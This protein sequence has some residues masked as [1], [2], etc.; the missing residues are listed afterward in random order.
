MFDLSWTEILLIGVAAIIFIGPKELPGA[1][2]ALGRWMGKARAMAREF[3]SNVDDM[4]RE[5]EIADLKKEVMKIES[6]EF[7]RE[8][9]KTVDPQGELSAALAPPDFSPAEPTAPPATPP[10]APV[11]AP[12]AA[13]ALPAAPPAAPPAPL[14]EAPPAARDATG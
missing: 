2:R 9:E 6:G 13:Q 10:V 4:I 7:A 3:Q 1:L 14:P 11:D 8:I 12:P 5:S